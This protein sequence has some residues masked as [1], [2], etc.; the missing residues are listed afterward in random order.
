MS[1]MGMQI[2]LDPKRV[3]VGVHNKGSIPNVSTPVLRPIIVLDM[4]CLASDKIKTCMV[5]EIH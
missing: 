5:S 4:I 2:T 1:F 3:P